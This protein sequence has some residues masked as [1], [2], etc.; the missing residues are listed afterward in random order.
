MAVIKQKAAV[1]KNAFLVTVRDKSMD[2]A[3][4]ARDTQYRVTDAGDVAS[5][6]AQVQAEFDSDNFT[7]RAVERFTRMNDAA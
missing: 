4:P 7:V 3:D 1:I 6:V 2:K 5:A